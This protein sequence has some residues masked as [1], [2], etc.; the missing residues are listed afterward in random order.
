MKH[1]LATDSDTSRPAKTS[2]IDPSSLTSA[3]VMSAT[4]ALAQALHLGV[5]KFLTTRDAV[6]VFSCCNTYRNDADLAKSVLL[7][8]PASEFTTHWFRDCGHDWFSLTPTRYPL[9][10]EDETYSCCSETIDA[11][12]S[13]LHALTRP[14]VTAQLVSL[15]GAFEELIL[16]THPSHRQSVSTYGDSVYAV[17]VAISLWDQHPKRRSLK[18]G[19]VWTREDVRVAL[20]EVDSGLGDRFVD[21]NRAK[22]HPS[23]LGAHWENIKMAKDDGRPVCGL[24]VKKGFTSDR[25]DVAEH[26]GECFEFSEDVLDEENDIDDDYGAG[27]LCYT[28]IQPL[29]HSLLKY[30]NFANRVK[31]D[32]NPSDEPWYEYCTLRVELLAGVSASGFLCGLFY[33]REENP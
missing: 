30:F 20:N 4:H 14:Q 15:I 32:V 29:K 8:G 9:G 12:S 2:K 18:P 1:Y 27:E 23:L 5:I 16:P 24:C 21:D 11:S 25:R 28:F 17:P 31:Y 22:S 19:H 3:S 13:V 33:L 10:Y 26:M 7:E 6:M